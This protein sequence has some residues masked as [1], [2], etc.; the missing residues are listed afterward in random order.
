VIF[1]EGFWNKRARLQEGFKK[2]AFDPKRTQKFIARHFPFP[3]L[4]L[5]LFQPSPDYRYAWFLCLIRFQFSDLFCWV[6]FLIY[7]LYAKIRPI[8]HQRSLNPFH[9]VF[10]ISYTNWNLIIDLKQ[11]SKLKFKLKLQFKFRSKSLIVR[12]K[13]WVDRVIQ[14]FWTAKMRSKWIDIKYYQLN[15]LIENQQMRWLNPNDITTKWR[16]SK[17]YSELRAFSMRFTGMTWLIWI[18]N[19]RICSS[20]KILLWN[21]LISNSRILVVKNHMSAME[22]FERYRIKNAHIAK[23]ADEATWWNELR[24]GIII[25]DQSP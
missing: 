15:W 3:F 4:F 1:C 6:N 19:Q 16:F 20:L 11:K 2:S 24:I 12:R 22:M 13:H 17:S 23:S 7:P 18:S 5:F 10:L 25:M 14:V 21:S 9:R 8:W